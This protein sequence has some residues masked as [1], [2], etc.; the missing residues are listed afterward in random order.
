MDANA[1]LQWCFQRLQEFADPEH[2]QTHQIPPAMHQVIGFAVDCRVI[3]SEGIKI[4]VSVALPACR[5]LSRL[6]IDVSERDP[7]DN[8]FLDCMWHVLGACELIDFGHLSRIHDPM[9]FDQFMCLGT[10]SGLIRTIKQ[11]FA[12]LHRLMSSPTF[13]ETTPQEPPCMVMPSPSLL[14]KFLVAIEEGG[15]PDPNKFCCR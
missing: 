2:S 8:K 5:Y 15:G 11:E 10:T 6:T 13:E 3:G 12:L 9:E 7:H 14:P 1:K 4:V